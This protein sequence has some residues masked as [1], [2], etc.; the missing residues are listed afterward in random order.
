MR[1]AHAVP[2]VGGDGQRQYG[3]RRDPG[4]KA[5]VHG[6]DSSGVVKALTIAGGL[7]HLKPQ[8]RLGGREPGAVP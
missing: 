6:Q 3:D 1:V 8:I 7:F 4:G 5:D 2:E